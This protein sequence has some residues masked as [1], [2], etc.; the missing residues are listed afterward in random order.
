MADLPDD[1]A[2]R[3]VATA[4][5][6]ELVRLKEQLELFAQGDQQQ[7]DAL[8]TVPAASASGG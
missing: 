5:R 6:E 8:R 3:S 7:W 1:D 4:V 2:P